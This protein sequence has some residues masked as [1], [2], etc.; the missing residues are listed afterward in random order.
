[1]LRRYL[2]IDDLKRFEEV[3]L[4]VLGDLDPKFELLPGE[5]WLASIQGNVLKYSDRIREGVAETL[6]A[7][8]AC[9]CLV[10]CA[11]T[12]DWA[13]RIAPPTGVPTPA[14]LWGVATV[15]GSAS[16]GRHRR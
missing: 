2:T 15:P 12:E 13:A 9:D 3:V 5:R 11:T 1:M 16:G 4:E 8:G 10:G 7:L 14:F 6:A